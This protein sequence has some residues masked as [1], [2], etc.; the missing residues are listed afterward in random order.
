MKGTQDHTLKEELGSPR[1]T[2]TSPSPEIRSLLMT[3][4]RKGTSFPRRALSKGGVMKMF[5]HSWGDI[6]TSHLPKPF[7]H[8]TWH[9][10]EPG[11]FGRM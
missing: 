4:L 2:S 8:V 6:A 3:F 11:A 5:L 9:R 10:P 1:I 7:L